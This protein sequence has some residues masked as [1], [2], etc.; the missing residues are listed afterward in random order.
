MRKQHFKR[1]MVKL[2]D[3]CKHIVPKRKSNK[4]ENC[5]ATCFVYITP[6]ECLLD[7][8]HTTGSPYSLIASETPPKYKY[9]K[10]KGIKTNL[11][12]R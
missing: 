6:E 5:L 1:R 7:F 2:H 3:I 8:T 4:N 11:T 12:V 9:F 10:E